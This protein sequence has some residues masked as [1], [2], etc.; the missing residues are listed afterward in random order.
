MSDRR[1]LATATLQDVA[2]A[3]GV[4]VGTVSKALNRREGVSPEVTSRIIDTARRLG[5]QKRQLAPQP[6][7]AIGSTTIVT[8][9]HFIVSGQF[10]G[11][12]LDAILEES[13]RQG[14]AT[15]VE[16]VPSGNLESFLERGRLFTAQRPESIIVLGIDQPELVDAIAAL[17]CPAVLVNGADR[18]MRVSSVS[19]DYHFGGWAAARHLLEQG[20]RNIAHVT[21][22]RRVSFALRLDGFRDALADFGIAYD[23]E[24]HLIDTQSPALMSEDARLAVEARM[25]AGTFDYTGFVCAADML[26]VGVMQAAAGAG[27]SIPDDISVIGFDDLPI[28]AHCN[29]PLSSIH[30]DRREIGRTAVSLLLE[31]SSL[32]QLPERRLAMGVSVTPRASVKDRTAS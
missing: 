12:I 25:S 13:E 3:A 27:L 24:I 14:I 30:V 16:L 22:L 1:K 5:Y 8:F 29:P 15:S 11:E 19:P 6:V 26:A 9:D 4:S 21:H 31:R 10:Y 7:Y 20:H 28:C 23:P 2:N 32:P 18:H 17:G